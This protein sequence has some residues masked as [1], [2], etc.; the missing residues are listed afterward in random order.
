[1]QFPRTQDLLLHRIFGKEN[2]RERKI[3]VSHRQILPFLP[4]RS[5]LSMGM[6]IG[7]SFLLPLRLFSIPNLMGIN[8]QPCAALPLLLQEEAWEE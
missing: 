1:M 2:I 8:L 4:L 5:C 7:P 6:Q 3:L